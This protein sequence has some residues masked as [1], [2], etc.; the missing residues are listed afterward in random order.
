MTFNNPLNSYSSVR[1]QIVEN[2]TLE[3]NN[4]IEYLLSSIK[5]NKVTET[6]ITDLAAKLVQNVRNRH[7]DQKGILAFIRQYNLSTEEGVVLM[8]LAEAL[9]RIPDAAT[10]D[11][12]IKDKLRLSNWQQYLG[13]SDSL[14]VNASTWGLM[15]SGKI[16]Q[17]KPGIANNP[18]EYLNSLIRKTSEPIIRAAL[19]EAM[20]IMGKQFVI[21]ETI[22]TAVLNDGLYSFDML[23]EAAITPK[24]ADDYFNS[25]CNA[26]KTVSQTKNNQ[27]SIS[28]KLSAL[29]CRYELTQQQTLIA[30]LYPKLKILIDTAIKFNVAITVDAEESNRLDIMLDAFEFMYHIAV[31]YQWP[32]LGLVVQAY[33]FRS[34]SIL[35]WLNDISKKNSCNISVRLVK[36]AYWDTEIKLAQQQGLDYYPVFTRKENTDLSYLNCAQYL[37]QCDYLFAQFASHNAHTIAAIV[38]YSQDFNKT[39]YEFQRLFGMGD[40]LYDCLLTDYNIPC[41]VYAPVGNYKSLLAYLVRRLLENGA[42]SSFV[43]RIENPDINIEVITQSPINNVNNNK[44]HH[45]PNIPLPH[46]IFLTESSKRKNSSGINLTDLHQLEQLTSAIKK[47]YTKLYEIKP[48]SNTAGKIMS[49]VNPA[50]HDDVIG[51]FQLTTALDV[52]AALSQASKSFDTWSKT[53]VSERVMILLKLA[54]LIE[55]NKQALI[56]LCVREAG[57]CTTDAISEIREAIDFCRYY[58][59]QATLLFTPISLIGPTGETNCL[60]MHARGVIA[61]ISPWNFPIAIFTGQICAALVTGNCV[62][63]KPAQQTSL[64]A[65]LITELCYQAGIPHDVLQ[66]IPSSSA[67]ISETLLAHPALSGVVFT[68]SHTSAHKI[69]IT[70]ASRSGA[71][72]PFIAETSGMNA[73]IVDSSALPEQ[74]VID[75][76]QSAFNSTGQRCSSLRFLYVQEEIADDI[77]ELLK[78]AV[79]QLTISDPQFLSTDMGPLIDQKSK[80]K[81]I[82]HIEFLDQN[83]FAMKIIDGRSSS[84]KYTNGYFI[85]PS[86]YEILSMSLITEEVFGPVLH[87]IRYKQSN[88]TNI[89]NEINDSGFGLTLGIHSRITNTIEEVIK[90]ARVGNIYVNRNIIGAVVGVQPFGGQQKS[91]TGPKAGGPNYLKTFCTEQHISNNITAIGGNSELYN[92]N[93]IT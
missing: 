88:L 45:N 31:K 22:A 54:D 75:V 73:L 68:G 21:A 9:L 62:L 91:G 18:G 81:I 57:R 50:N 64:C 83:D 26:I 78:G 10:A 79:S 53:P 8:C 60:T 47:N 25:Y 41:R 38:H 11:K 5:I 28:I 72:I 32:K 6:A 7:S 48:D 61:C 44:I 36:G 4:Y 23:G 30:E 1:Q 85:S 34:L 65:F 15:L 17:I 77:I 29:H 20:H 56:S 12:L 52:N 33:Q 59:Q 87:L 13:E 58:S 67:E 24:M 55:E 49:S 76:I 90:N 92:G 71:I 43:Q 82:R 19:K 46:D 80:D 93:Y 14:F 35:K 63:A 40:L 39:S 27:N 84:V 66:L 70:L 51:N 37:L 89:V 3:E 74:V 86:I 42:N 2:Y 69:K 16:I